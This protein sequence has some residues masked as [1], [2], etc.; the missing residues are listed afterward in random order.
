VAAIGVALLWP[1]GPT[2]NVPGLVCFG[3]LFAFNLRRGASPA[4]R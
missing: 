4:E 3:L 2:V 1:T